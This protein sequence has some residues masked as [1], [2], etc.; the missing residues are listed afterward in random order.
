VCQKKKKEEEEEEGDEEESKLH[1]NFKI[2]PPVS[3]A[4]DKRRPSQE[5]LLL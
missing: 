1:E 5:H 3:S 4:E 2:T